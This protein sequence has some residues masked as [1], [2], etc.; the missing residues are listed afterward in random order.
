MR[1]AQPCYGSREDVAGYVVE[2]NERISLM[3]LGVTPA[4]GVGPPG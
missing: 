1:S 4:A 2:G 3:R